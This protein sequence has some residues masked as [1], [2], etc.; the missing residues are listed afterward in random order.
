[1]TAPTSGGTTARPSN[2]RYKP[3]TPNA[4][5]LTAICRYITASGMRFSIDARQRRL[6]VDHL[7]QR[8]HVQAWGAGLR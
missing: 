2:D 5:T 7:V 4:S 6:C 3:S 8:F 1:M